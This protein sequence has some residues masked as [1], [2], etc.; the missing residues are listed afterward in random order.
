MK[1]TTTI[2]ALGLALTAAITPTT[3]AAETAPASGDRA[4]QAMSAKLASAKQFSFHA[5][6][7]IDPALLEGRDAPEKAR[8]DVRVA[9]PNRLAARSVSQEGARRVIADGRNLT[10]VDEKKNFYGQVPMRT[11]IDGLVAQLDEKYGFI[12]PLA[13]FAVS[14]P[15]AEI[16]QQ[17]HT[18][19][20]MGREKISGGGE[21]DHLALKGK[22]ADVELWIGV[23]DQLPRKLVATFHRAGR[24]Q[25]R[26]A[27]SNWNLAAPVAASDFTF[28]PPHGAQKIEMWTKAQMQAANKTPAATKH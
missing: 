23:S 7:E 2:A 9:R 11:S 20:S 14:N 13:D 25:L 28:T 18:I 16:Q 15:Y 24:P 5:E 4:L 27:F 1:H 17:A 6:R 22:E 3:S 8:I 10:V 19:T 26:I 12:P 21:C